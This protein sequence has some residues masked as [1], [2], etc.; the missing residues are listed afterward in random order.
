MAD[1]VDAEILE[2]FRRQMRDDRSG[3]VILAEYRLISFKTQRRQPFRDVHR[4]S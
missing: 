1:R 4:R 2:V 3:D